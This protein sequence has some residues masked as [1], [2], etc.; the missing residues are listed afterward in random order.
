MR[1]RKGPNS[2]LLYFR[3]RGGKAKC[4]PRRVLKGDGVAPRV[5]V[6][7]SLFELMNEFGKS[8]TILISQNHAALPPKVCSRSQKIN[9]GKLLSVKIA[10]CHRVLFPAGIETNLQLCD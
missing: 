2:D 7:P 10:T 9:I 3:P 6:S 5:G 8:G 4:L 1:R